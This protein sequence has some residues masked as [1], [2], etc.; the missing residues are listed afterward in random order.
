MATSP[1]TSQEPSEQITS[2][3][4]LGARLTWSFIGPAALLLT[5]FGIISSGEGWLTKLDIL[6]AVVVVWMLFGRWFDQQ[7]TSDAPTAEGRPAKG[8][9]GRYVGMLLAIAA[10]AWLVANVLGNHLLA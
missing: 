4:V 6:F 10:G 3:S 7:K 1:G 5:S 2:A 8:P 9:F